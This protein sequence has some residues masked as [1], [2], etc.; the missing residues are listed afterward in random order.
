M[1]HPAHDRVRSL[2]SFSAPI[3]L[4]GT[5][6]SSLPLLH[7]SKLRRCR[8]R[9]VVELAKV[10]IIVAT[11]KTTRCIFQRLC[12]LRHNS[13]TTTHRITDLF[14][15]RR[16]RQRQRRRRLLFIARYQLPTSRV[17]I[18]FCKRVSFFFFLRYL[19]QEQQQ[20]S[21]FRLG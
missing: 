3:C 7:K 21:P 10:S 11:K 14:R 16:R 13:K 18:L 20:S 4:S 5:I 6:V 17:N 8:R 9:R 15:Y 19:Q 12:I 2:P 1:N